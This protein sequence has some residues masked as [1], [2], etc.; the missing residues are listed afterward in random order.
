[1]SKNT[2]LKTI[3][4]FLM[5]SGVMHNMASAQK[6]DG[7]FLGYESYAN[8][9]EDNSAFYLTNQF[10][11]SDAN[12]G[13]NLSNQQFGAELPLGGGMLI[14]LGAGAVYALRKRKTIDI[15]N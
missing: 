14:M 3:A 13:F 5:L 4:I 10:F 6:S 2:L 1:M 9:G 15:G 7:L 12:G 8:R 11:G